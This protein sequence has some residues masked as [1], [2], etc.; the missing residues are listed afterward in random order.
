MEVLKTI[1]VITLHLIEIGLGR[2][3]LLVGLLFHLVHRLMESSHLRLQIGI[4][5]HQLVGLVSNTTKLGLQLDHLLTKG[6]S[7]LLEFL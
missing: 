7:R 3:E 6:L 1:P 2:L 4:L 5:L